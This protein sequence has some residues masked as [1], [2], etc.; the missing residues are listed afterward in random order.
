[1]KNNNLKILVILVVLFLVV[2]ITLFAL[3]IISVLLFWAIIIVA[4][5][6][7]YKVMPKLKKRLF[8]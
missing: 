6:F 5:I 2:N 4:A 8:I 3:R 1:M 7:A